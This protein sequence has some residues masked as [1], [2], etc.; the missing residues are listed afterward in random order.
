MMCA[1]LPAVETVQRQEEAAPADEAPPQGYATE[2]FPATENNDKLPQA[3]KASPAEMDAR[4]FS[5]DE[6]VDRWCNAV[7]PYA[8][9][10]CACWG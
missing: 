1:Y 3:A 2:L 9:Q 6:S 10:R 8:L 5:L 7:D 4:T